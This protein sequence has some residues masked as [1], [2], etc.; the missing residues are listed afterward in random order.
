MYELHILCRFLI[1]KNACA[2]V[3]REGRR[4]TVVIVKMTRS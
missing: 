3:W 2:C 4:G 1:S